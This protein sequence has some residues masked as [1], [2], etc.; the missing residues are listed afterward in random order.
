MHDAKADDAPDDVFKLTSSVDGKPVET[1][2]NVTTK[3]G[4]NNVATKVNDAPSS[5]GSRRT[6]PAPR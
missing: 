2:D 3:E 1:Y 6:T 4:D 5:S